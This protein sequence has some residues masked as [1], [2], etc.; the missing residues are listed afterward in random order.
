MWKCE[1]KYSKKHKWKT[2]ENVPK[3]KK[4]KCEQKC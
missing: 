2:C 1:Q 3:E 4:E